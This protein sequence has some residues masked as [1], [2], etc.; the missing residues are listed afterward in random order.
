[1]ACK[2]RD[3]VMKEYK[4]EEDKRSIQRRERMLLDKSKRDGVQARRERER[5]KLS[6]IHLITDSEELSRTLLEIDS[7]QISTSQKK[8]KKMEVLKTQIKI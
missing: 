7:L 2:R 8:A 1:M 6:T 4:E 3:L 5:N